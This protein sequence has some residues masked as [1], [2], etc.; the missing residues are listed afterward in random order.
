MVDVILIAQTRAICLFAQSVVVMLAAGIHS[1]A[2]QRRLTNAFDAYEANQD[3]ST[4]W[5]QE[6]FKHT[7][8]LPPVAGMHCAKKCGADNMQ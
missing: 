8:V 6:S 7:V 5:F 3:V 4:M 1:I 2:W